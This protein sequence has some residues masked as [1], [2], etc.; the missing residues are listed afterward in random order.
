MSKLSLKYTLSLLIAFGTSSSSLLCTPWHWYVTHLH[1]SNAIKH[2]EFHILEFDFVL[3]VYDKD[4]H[5]LFL[6][7]QRIDQ[8]R[9]TVPLEEHQIS[10]D[11]TEHEGGERWTIRD[12]SVP[13]LDLLVGTENNCLRCLKPDGNP[14]TTLDVN[15]LTQQTGKQA[16]IVAGVLMRLHPYCLILPDADGTYKQGFARLREQG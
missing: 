2:V 15:L 9:K 10:V 5:E 8:H 12:G 14:A 7:L 6:T 1:L 4:T 3:R 13:I 16:I 11:S